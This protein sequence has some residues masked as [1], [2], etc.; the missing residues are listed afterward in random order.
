LNASFVAMRWVTR[1]LTSL[2]NW[3]PFARIHCGIFSPM[4]SWNLPTIEA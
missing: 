3:P 4:P 1:G 2:E